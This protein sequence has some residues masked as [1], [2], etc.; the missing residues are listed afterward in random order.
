M[1]HGVSVCARV[2]V[3]VY[4][5]TGQHALKQQTIFV[6]SDPSAL[7]AIKNLQKL[8]AIWTEGLI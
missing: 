7:T 8:E 2:P 5:H 1:V 6:S 3:C 4:R